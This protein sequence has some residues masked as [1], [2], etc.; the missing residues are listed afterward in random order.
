M[1]DTSN[2]FVRDTTDFRIYFEGDDFFEDA[3][4]D[5]EAARHSIYIEMYILEADVIGLK[6]K[7]ILVRKLGQGLSVKL[8]IDGIGSLSLPQSYLEELRQLGAEA[9]IFHPFTILSPFR[10]RLNQRNHRKVVIIDQTV[11]YL[12]GMNF[13]K[14]LSRSAVGESRWRDTHVRTINIDLVNKLVYHFKRSTK[15]LKHRSKRLERFSHHNDVIASGYHFQRNNIRRLIH[16][17]I[18][19]SRSSILISTAYFIPDLETIFHLMRSHKRG[20]DIKI[21]TPA[22]ECSDV[23]TVNRINGIILRYLIKRGIKVYYYQTRMMHA[24]SIIFDQQLVTVG[25][26][27]INYRSFFRDLEINLFLRKSQL[28]QSFISQ[29]ELDLK[30]SRPVTLEELNKRSWLDR[31]IDAS[32]Y[33]IRSFF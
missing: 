14:V 28:V 9:H 2:K 33:L 31:I 19:K 13:F 1:N 25:S 6:L 15:E 21:I 5:L 3:F 4:L 8:L 17:Y 32:L 26:S 27:N 20:V 18:K 12:G 11:G 23:K 24:K 7:D 10:K 30:Q 22:P 29:F 16:R